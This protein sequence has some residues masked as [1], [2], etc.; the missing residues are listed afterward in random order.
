MQTAEA[1]L[2]P[3]ML[4]KASLVVFVT[5]LFFFYELGLF[6]IFDSLE[7][8]IAAEYHLSPTYMGFV[9][10]LDFYTNILFLI[11]AGILLDRYSP[12]KLI[13]LAMLACATGVMMI[14]LSHSL[15]VMIIARL[16]MGVGGGF[17]FI[18]NVRIAANWFDSHHMARASGFIVGMGMLGGFMAQAPMTLLIDS[19]DWRHALSIVGII[20]YGIM[21]LIW[22]FV[23]DY[24]SYRA[25]DDAERMA[26]LHQIGVWQSLKLA[27]AS[28]QNWLCG[29][30]A[31]LMNLPI[32]MLGALWGIPYLMQVD[33]FSNTVAAN[34]AGMLFIGSMIGSPLAG[35]LSDAIGYRRLPMLVCAVV[36]I[37]L[38]EITTHGAYSSTTDLL[39]LFF[40]LGLFTSSQVIS[41]PVVVE[42]NSSMITSTATSVISMSCLGGG[43]IIQPLFG[44]LLSMRGHEQLINGVTQYPAANYSFAISALPIAFLIALAVA[45]FVRETYC[46][47]IVE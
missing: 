17:C 25:G 11:P 38:I 29:V 7:S 2:S 21:L 44:Y 30:Y 12:R 36:S 27:L 20:G 14:A 5:S 9:S 1:T 22:L 8:Y 43:V 4:I 31:S 34:I 3:S 28:R 40:L 6:N 47:S 18:G 32:F 41:Y 46:N 13:C 10:S 24:P 35:W 16:L 23:R 42:S 39:V 33:G 19:L 15:A 37:I 45:W 26:R